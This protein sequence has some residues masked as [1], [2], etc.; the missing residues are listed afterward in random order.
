[1]FLSIEDPERSVLVGYVR[2]RLDAAG[3]TVR[4]LKVF[5]RLVPIHAAPEGRWQHRGM[6]R[7]LMD[8][9]ESVAR[10]EFHARR[11]R[12]TSGVGVRGYYRSLGYGLEG[13]YMVREL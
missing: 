9:A 4:E 6:G 5:G 8:A 3:A 7:R 1:M 2:L 12:V 11:M 13:P 10:D